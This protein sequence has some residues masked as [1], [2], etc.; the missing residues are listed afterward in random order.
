MTVSRM[1]NNYIIPSLDRAIEIIGFLA[2]QPKGCGITAIADKLGYP[3]NSVF[4]ILK[5]LANKGYIIETD[6]LYQLSAKFLAIGYSA[7]G[8]AHMVEK[9]IDVMRELRDEVNETVLLGT[10]VGNRGIILEQVLSTQPLKVMVDPG[11]NFALHTAAPAK[12]IL[13]YMKQDNQRKIIETITY[14]RFN[15]NTIITKRQFLKSLKE[16]RKKGYATDLA[17]E[18]IN[19]H[20]VACPIFNHKLEPIASIWITGPSD[21]LQPERFDEFGDIIG[22]FALRISRRLGYE[23][24]LNGHTDFE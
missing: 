13:A 16:A 3:K 4:R 10:L 14:T 21:R 22:E 7:V 2:K 17:E 5:T 18:I 6:R 1:G 8:E 19:L 15:E 11:H 9:A 12:A 24:E 23:P 20:C